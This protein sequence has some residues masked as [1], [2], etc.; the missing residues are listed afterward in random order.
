[1]QRN[2]VCQWLVVLVLIAALV[3]AFRAG[4]END[5]PGVWTP[6]LWRFLAIGGLAAV[7]ALL[8]RAAS[9]LV[10][11]IRDQREWYASGEILPTPWASENRLVRLWHKL[12]EKH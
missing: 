1:M 7:I 8:A 2:R 12:T 4:M 9:A 11:W 5:E 10:Q 3:A 6:S